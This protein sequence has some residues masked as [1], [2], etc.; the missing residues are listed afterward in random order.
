MC[1]ED[2][3]RTASEKKM[4]QKAQRIY[5]EFVAFRAPR[6]VRLQ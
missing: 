3:K 2:Y 1:S 5:S 6:E 4:V